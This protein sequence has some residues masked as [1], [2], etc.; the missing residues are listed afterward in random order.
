MAANADGDV[1]AGLGAD[2]EADR[3]G[4]L[5]EE[6]MPVVSLWSYAQQTDGLGG[7]AW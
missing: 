4:S 7:R 5:P 1:L 6:L 3:L 2:R